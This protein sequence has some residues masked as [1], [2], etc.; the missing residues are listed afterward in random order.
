VIALSAVLAVALA[1]PAAA[2]VKTPAQVVRAW[3]NV[4]SAGNDK[5]AGA[6]FA[7][8]ALTVQGSFVVRLT[9]TKSAV[10]WN[11][12]LPCSGVI[13]HLKVRG[14]VVTATFVLGHRKGHKCDGPGQLAAA[15]FTVVNGKITRWE[16]VAPDKPEPVA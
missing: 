13:T 16:Q 11:S 8:G 9:T 3:S 5:A 7:P 14:N 12:G 2:K 10:V 6:L 4:L 15:K 1:G